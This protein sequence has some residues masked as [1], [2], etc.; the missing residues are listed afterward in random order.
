MDRGLLFAQPLG[1]GLLFR[2]LRR[3]KLSNSDERVKAAFSN[4]LRVRKLR[5]ALMWVQAIDEEP[6]LAFRTALGEIAPPI[7]G[8]EYVPVWVPTPCSA[9]DSTA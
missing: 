9:P 7:F 5:T 1:T 8:N 3:R 4:S 6:D 2:I